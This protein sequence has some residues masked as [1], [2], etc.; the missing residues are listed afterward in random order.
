MLQGLLHQCNSASATYLFQQ[1][2]LHLKSN[3]R[4]RKMENFRISSTMWAMTLETNQSSAD[5]KLTP[6][7]CGSC[8]RFE[9]YTAFKS[10]ICFHCRR[11]VRITWRPLWTTRLPWQTTWRSW[12]VLITRRFYLALSTSRW[13]LTQVFDWSQ[14]TQRGSAPTLGSGIFQKGEL[15]NNKNVWGRKYAHTRR[16][17]CATWFDRG[18]GLSENIKI[19]GGVDLKMINAHW[20]IT[21]SEFNA[22]LR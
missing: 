22:D 14:N 3:T 9:F 13:E 7:N 4:N 2:S 20:C 6:S 12:W 17:C 15:R 10:Q 21:N 1:V 11:G 5:A 16:D 18:L 8:W 19:C